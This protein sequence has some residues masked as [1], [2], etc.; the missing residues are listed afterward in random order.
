M[1]ITDAQKID[2]VLTRG[3]ETVLPTKEKFA[4][5]LASG[6]RLRIYLGFD[7][8]APFLHIGHALQ[9]KKLR[10]FQELGH[11]VIWLFGTFTAMIGDP[12]D[13]LAARKQL[14][15]EE[16][17][18]NVA[19]YKKIASKFLRFRGDNAVKILR[20]DK[21][22]SKLSFAD[23][24]D[25]ASNFTVQQMMERDMFEKRFYGSLSCN[26]C[27]RA[28]SAK[29][30]VK[31]I[32]QEISGK[33]DSNYISSATVS[34]IDKQFCPNCNTE[35]SIPMN[36]ENSKPIGLHEFMYPLMQGYDSV[37]MDVDAEIGGND[38]TFNMLAGRT[39]QRAMKGR[40]KYVV[41]LKLLTNDEGKKMSKS[42]GGFIAMNDTPEEMYGKIMSMSDG[43]I[44]PYFELVT[45][46]PKEEIDGVRV[47][48]Q[49]GANPR[50]MKMRLAKTVVTMFH[51][52]AAAS[53]GEA[54][55][56]NV[57]QKKETPDEMTD[58]RI[59][60][61][62]TLADLLVT[63]KLAESKGEARRLVEQG[64]IALDDAK[65]S[66]AFQTMAPGTV[67]VLRR[68]KRQFVRLVA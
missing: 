20:N 8:T 26:K 47:A 48:L 59:E 7:P 19:N 3:V 14:T 31:T 41:A 55:F 23:V 43:M 52:A 37:A 15:K 40:E 35:F 64:G 24:V 32:T 42:E 39:L 10:E 57:F 53:R 54:H 29:G 22:L 49:N 65:L 44:V 38:Q 28:I 51:N 17:M 2:S 50:D 12:T 13:K 6:Q 66:D 33:T 5:L 67:G 58:F 25:I 68:G 11:E 34:L 18:A 62:M 45:D 16:V 1:V 4:T 9:L 63:T 30:R 46:L 56:V 36:F 61:A 27:H 60:S 21:W